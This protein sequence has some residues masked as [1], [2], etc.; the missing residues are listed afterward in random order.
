MLTPEKLATLPSAPGV[1]QFKNAAGQVIYVGKAKNLRARVRSYFLEARPEEPKTDT[2][3]REAADVGTILVDNEREALALE[4]NLIKQLQPR[5]NVLLR[6]D[7]TYP[8]IKLTMAEKY[9]RIYVTRR[10]KK[11]GSLYFGPYFP[12]G[13]AHRIAHFIHRTF[14]VPSCT[15]DLTRTHSRPC[16][17]YYIQ[18]CQGPCVA[19]LTTDERYAR[20]VR[21]VRMFLEGRHGDL[22]HELRR[23]MQQ[24]SDAERFEEAAACR[25]LISTVEQLEEKQKM[26]SAAGDDQDIF[27]YHQEGPLVAVNVFHTRGGRVVDRRE[28]FWENQDVFDPSEFFSSLLKQLYL[29]QRYI[30]AFLHV[31]ADFEDRAL[32]EEFLTEKRGR[33]VEILTPQRGP[34]RAFLDLAERNA[35]LSFEQRFRVLQPSAKAIAES[36]QESLDL[37]EPPRRIECFDVSHIQGTDTVAS[38][39]VWE[40]GRMRKSEYRKF[41]VKTVAGN[42]DFASMRE[43]VGRRYRRLQEEKKPLPELILI[44]GG[45][46]QLHAASSAL[47]ELG[48]INQPLASIA[49]KEEI[50]YVYGQESD[51][52]RL[53]RHSPVLHLIQQVRDES[54]RF[55]VRFHRQRRDAR[56]LQSELLAVPGIG[57]R[58]A[59]RLLEH[60]GSVERL[61]AASDDELLHVLNRRQAAALRRFIESSKEAPILR[62]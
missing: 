33:K 13:L 61:R 58:T 17:Q 46:G 60:F 31:P 39:V 16:L 11:D 19:G 4:N 7:K 62:T 37:P 12:G 14:Q 52:V 8:Y 6:D 57:E 15:V 1:Y 10:L 38:M 41:I 18:R 30:P 51:P 44:D 49:K 42:D 54:H 23:R 2:L 20:A 24:A 40:N 35:A 27:G 29:D 3:V 36:L 26:A 43:V 21:D 34:K 56:R 48:I 55:A 47:E 28:F 25:N 59:R 22:L 53:D 45:I 9:P 5:F 32:L 50:L